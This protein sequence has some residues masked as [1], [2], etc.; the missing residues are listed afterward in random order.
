MALASYHTQRSCGSK[1]EAG[2]DPSC[3]LARQPPVVSRLEKDRPRVVSRLASQSRGR[4]HLGRRE[5]MVALTNSSGS[6]AAA[7]I[8][9]PYRCGEP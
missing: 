5:Q 9:A 6:V 3:V 7:E 1:W 4:V 2:P 8:L